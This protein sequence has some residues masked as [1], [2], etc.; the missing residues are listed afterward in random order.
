MLILRFNININVNTN[1][2][3]NDHNNDTNNNK[4]NMNIN[5]NER[6]PD[7][8]HRNLKAFREHIQN[9]VSNCFITEQYFKNL[10]GLGVRV[11]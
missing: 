1:N 5:I 4:R 10:P 8:R 7:H 11:V 2:T 6:F 3:D 9:M